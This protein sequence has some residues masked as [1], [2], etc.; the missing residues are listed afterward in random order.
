MTWRNRVTPWGTLV[1]TPDRGTLMGNRGVLID[2]QG[3]IVREAQ[4]RR[5]IACVLSFK[6][7]HR[8]VMTPGQYTELFFL[9]EATAFAAGH[10]PCAECRRPDFLAFQQIWRT[11]TDAS[12]ARAQDIDRRL[13]AERTSYHGIKKT[14]VS[15][16]ADLP[17]G[18]VV[19]RDGR[20]WLVWR[21]AFLEWTSGG[22]RTRQPRFAGPVEVLTPA[23]L[24]D[25][26]R[27]RYPVAV[28]ASAD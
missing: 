22:Y 23:T 10:R 7:R 12:S 18:A 6:N 9:D 26:L 28:H 8:A 24:V 15:N 2:A 1:A 13:A 3:R 27:A 19:T 5:W 16:G 20:A 14:F 4:T 21:D 11:V 17:D 25:V